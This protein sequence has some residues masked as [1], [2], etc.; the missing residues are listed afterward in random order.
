MGASGPDRP[1][2][3]LS[4]PP[5]PDPTVPLDIDVLGVQRAPLWAFAYVSVPTAPFSD[6]D[7]SDLL[8]A[9]RR[10]NAAHHVTGKLLVLEDGDTLT[11]FA[12]WIEGPKGGIDACIERIKADDRHAILDVVRHGQADAR[13]FPGWD[14]D[15]QPASSMTFAPAAAELTATGS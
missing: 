10:F 2:R 4:C 9:A 5:P 14:M 15:I 11:R 6:R 13:R 3:G 12:Q 7:L 8:L 1:R